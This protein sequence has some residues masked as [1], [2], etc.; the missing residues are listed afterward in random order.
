MIN[1]AFVA[2][3]SDE[4]IAKKNYLINLLFA[5][6]SHK[7]NE[8]KIFI[9]CGKKIDL[10]SK[11]DFKKYSTVIEDSLFDPL[12][13]KWC[14]MKIENKFFGTNYLLEKIFL[15]YNINILSHNFFENLKS[16]K[17]IGWIPDFQHINLPEMFPKKIINERNKRFKNLIK[18][19]H[20][21]LLSS[22]DAL[23]DFK[24]FDL[25]NMHKVKVLNFV[26]QPDSKYDNFDEISKKDLLEKY[27]IKD[28]YYYIPNQFWKHKNHMLVFK[29]INEF[30]KQN[31]NF[32]VVCSGYLKDNRNK[33]YYSDVK[34]YLTQ[35]NL[36]DNIKLLGLIDYQD[37]FALIKFSEAVINPSLF[38]GWSSTVEECKSVGKQ[39]ILSDI[40]VHKE[41]YENANFFLKNNIDSFKNALLN[42]K[43]KNE[44]Q[45]KDSLE[46]RTKKF[47]DIY[48]DILKKINVSKN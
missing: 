42:F 48:S 27:D 7:K 46:N 11:N 3:I 13:I 39:M 12:S 1:V 40:N 45:Y 33:K 20:I 16:I 14:L 35:N 24:K 6:Q 19:S 23:N 22:Y 44:S 28:R 25:E 18:T 41:Q 15:K 43:I 47:A 5:L 4:W 30:K 29:A 36:T 38:E 32:N 21:I 34:N 8:F 2:N 31:I 10:E 37:V 9:F 26:C 17:T